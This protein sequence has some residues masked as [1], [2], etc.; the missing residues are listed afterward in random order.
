MQFSRISSAFI[1]VI[2]FTSCSLATINGLV[3]Q[4]N[5]ITTYKNSYFSDVNTDYVYK[6]QIDIYGNYFG[7]IMIFKKLGK[8]HHRVVFTTEFGSKIFDFE[9]KGE[10]FT[11]KYIIDDLDRKLIVN[12]LKN[13]FKTLL[14]EKNTIIKSFTT[15]N[16]KVF[17]SSEGKRYNFFFIE[18]STNQLEKIVHT[19]KRKEKVVYNFHNVNDK[20]A[21]QINIQHKNIKL[22]INLN[23][24]ND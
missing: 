5:S 21:K 9:F 20:I 15:S 19:S 4:K 24:I 3:E 18:N 17:Q 11:K 13:D 10:T 16:M 8:D 7:G 2:L 22:N 6:T 23:Y 1:L 14:K 12:T